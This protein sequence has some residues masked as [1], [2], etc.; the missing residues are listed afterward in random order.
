MTVFGFIGVGNMGGAL[1]RAAAKALP[2]ELVLLS[3]RT[4]AKA[5]AL[6]TELGC[7]VASV[8]EVAAEADFVIGLYNPSSHKRPDYLQR[9]CD[10]LLVHKDPATVCGTVRNI[11]REGEEAHVLTLGELRDTPVD[12]FTTV[13]VGNSQTRDIDGRMVTPRGYLQRGR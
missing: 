10:I 5:E 4:A 8:A 3:N 12:M 11:G 2:G 1:A 6:A 7:R 9:A 13:F